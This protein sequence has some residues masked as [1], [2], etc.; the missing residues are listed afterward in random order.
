MSAL[1]VAKTVEI[2]RSQRI[3]MVQTL[4]QYEYCYQVVVDELEELISGYNAE[5]K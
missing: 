2:F 5:K 1:D 3:G 4:D